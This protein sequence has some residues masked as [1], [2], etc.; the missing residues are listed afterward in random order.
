[1]KY[2]TGFCNRQEHQQIVLTSAAAP[3][4]GPAASYERGLCWAAVFLRPGC[5]SGSV[6]QSS[7]VSPDVRPLTL[8]TPDGEEAVWAP[9][10]GA[11][12]P[13][14]NPTHSAGSPP[15]GS[16]PNHFASL[17]LCSFSFR[18]LSRTGWPP[19]PRL[20]TEGVRRA[21]WERL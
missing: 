7:E 3:G 10:W 21:L 13:G 16:G 5:F 6:T 20:G 19:C 8:S 15:R 4:A 12:D 17:N 11:G 14:C 2:D 1:M 9:G 18:K